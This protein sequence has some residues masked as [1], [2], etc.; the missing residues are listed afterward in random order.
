MHRITLFELC[1][2]ENHTKL[3]HP[4]LREHCTKYY[5]QH[6]TH[7]KLR[8]IHKPHIHTIYKHIYYT[9]IYR[10]YRESTIN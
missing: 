8:L 9:D 10:E 7:R 2:E 6:H 4:Y 3:Q 1:D 5:T